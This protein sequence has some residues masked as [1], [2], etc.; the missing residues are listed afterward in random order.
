MRILDAG[1]GTG[2]ATI[3]LAQQFADLNVKADIVYIDLSATSRAIAE[4]RA[5]VRR[6]TGITFMTGS[7]LDLSPEL[8]GTF[9]FINCS[10][11]IHHLQDP[12]AGLSALAKC[13]RPQG[14]IFLMVYAP[15]GRAGVYPLQEM[16]KDTAPPTESPQERI[17]RS[18]KLIS[19]LPQQNL[20][21]KCTNIIDHRGGDAGIFDLLLHSIDRPYS[22][23]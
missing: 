1:G 21:N 6:L 7:L 14:G 4:E 22:V 3:G 12:A 19:A 8:V 13:L 10:G 18:K 16:L 17:R 11:V 23:N 20:F 2:D 9:D 5:N 15:Y